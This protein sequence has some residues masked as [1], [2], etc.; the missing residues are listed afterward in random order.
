MLGIFEGTRKIL[1]Q[2]K[3]EFVEIEHNRYFPMGCGEGRLGTINDRLLIDRS[4]KR[5]LRRLLTSPSTV[6]VHREG[7]DH[8]EWSDSN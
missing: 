8:A 7:R 1:K 4:K 3:I 2:L 5:L 6:L